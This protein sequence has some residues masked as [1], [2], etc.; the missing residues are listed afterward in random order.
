MISLDII[1]CC[2]VLNFLLLYNSWIKMNKFLSFSDY[3]H[4]DRCAIYIIDQEIEQRSCDRMECDEVCSHTAT[5][6]DMSLIR[7]EECN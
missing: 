1:L 6:M 2:N 7:G 3:I 5:N 4:H